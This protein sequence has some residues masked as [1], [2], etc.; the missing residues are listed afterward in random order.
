MPDFHEFHVV[1]RE[2]HIKIVAVHA[3]DDEDAKM[4]VN[5]G[6]GTVIDPP[7]FLVQL[8]PDLWEVVP[9]ATEGAAEAMQNPESE[10]S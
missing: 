1:V 4:R 2:V 10:G 6:Q 3:R 9:P 7:K 5:G 8:S